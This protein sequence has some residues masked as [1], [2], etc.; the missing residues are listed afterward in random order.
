VHSITLHV[1]GGVSHLEDEPPGP[2]AEFLI[3]GVGPL[4][5][6][7]IALVLG[8]I[9]ASGVV[10]AGSASAILGYL[11]AVN[12]AVGVFNLI[13]G[14]PLDGGRLLRAVLWRWNGTLPRATYV[15]SRVGVAFAFALMTL[16]V[17][18]ILT[19]LIVGGFW[20]ILIG[21]FLR[22][23]A[24][25][26]TQIALREELARLRVRDVMARDVVSVSPDAPLDQ[27]VDHFWARHFTS[28][29]VTE[30]ETVLGIASVQQLHQVAEDRWRQTRVRGVMRR[31]DDELVVRPGDSVFRA[32]E[33]A[34]ANRLGRLAVLDDSLRLVGYLSLKDITHVLALRGLAGGTGPAQPRPRPLRRAA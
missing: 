33:K 1:F 15:A 28:F 2:R 5:S 29:P 19:G 8:G 34:S 4:T 12:F 30:G 7:G 24:A 31:L 22:A 3:A 14:F 18:Q 6:F 25:S 13:P 11:A 21:F 17:L 27:L 23:A 10:G 32:L 26:Y 20:L 9:R 16:G